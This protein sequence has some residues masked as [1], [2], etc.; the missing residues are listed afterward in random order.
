MSSDQVTVLD[1]I[2]IVR[3]ERLALELF[4][5]VHPLRAARAIET[6]W[7]KGLLSGA[8]LRATLDELAASGRNGIVALREFVEA[9]PTDWIPP[10]SNLE[11]RFAA[12]MA[13]AGLG[14]W[15]R[16]VDLGDTCWVGR[17]D[18]LHDRRPVIVEVQ[19]ERYH[20]ALLDRAADAER[21]A[22]LEAGGFVVV[23]VWDTWIWHDKARVLAAVRRA[24][25]GFSRLI[26]APESTDQTE[27]AGASG[28]ADG[29]A[30]GGEGGF[31]VGDRVL[32]EVEDAGG[33]HGV[34]AALD[35]AL[36]EVLRACR[37]RRWRPPARGRR[38]RPPAS[39]PGRSRPWCR[40]GPST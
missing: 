39:A 6:A 2:P 33:E 24:L 8:S 22:K 13:T 17:V 12:I 15:H 20:T 1:G 3:P 32:A 14:T 11:A 23:E 19:S 27:N 9:R 16:Q 7:T 18:F 31:G 38:R 29:D 40:R 37:R 10:A 5:S 34:G 4:A 35:H 25:D 28:G 26:R 21:K 36:D 30:G